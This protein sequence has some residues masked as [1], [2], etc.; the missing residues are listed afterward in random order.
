MKTALSGSV[1]VVAF[2]LFVRGSPWV[3]GGLS[4]Q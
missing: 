1:V 4:E 2:E 3:I